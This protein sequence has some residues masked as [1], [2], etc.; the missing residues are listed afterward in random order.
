MWCVHVVCACGDVVCV[1]GVCMW[2]VHVVMWCV[3][4]VMWSVSVCVYVRMHYH[5]CYTFASDHEICTYI[6]VPVSC[7]FRKLLPLQFSG[8]VLCSGPGH[9]AGSHQVSVCWSSSQCAWSM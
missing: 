7:Q 6:H 9:A 2:C 3:H 5:M 1:C 4:V 8:Q